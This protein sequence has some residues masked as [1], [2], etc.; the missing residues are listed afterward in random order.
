[1]KVRISGNS[2]R[3]CL[4]QPEVKQFEQVGEMSEVIIFGPAATEKLSFI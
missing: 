3:F 1:M 4:K 2:I